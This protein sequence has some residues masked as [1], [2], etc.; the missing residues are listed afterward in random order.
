[1]AKG[2]LFVLLASVLLA[3][4]VAGPDSTNSV[5]AAPQAPGVTA[6][7]VTAESGGTLPSNITRTNVTTPASDAGNG[8]GGGLSGWAIFFI[9]LAVLVAVGA[10]GY[11]ISY[12]CGWTN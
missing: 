3:M 8:G 4:M 6:D 12:V 5:S 2:I 11:G 10:I 9:V 1:M 7:M